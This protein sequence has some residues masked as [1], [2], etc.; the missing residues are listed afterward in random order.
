MGKLAS[1]SPLPST[2]CPLG[3]GDIWYWSLTFRVGFLDS[4][5]R[6]YSYPV[7]GSECVS[8]VHNDSGQ[9]LLLRSHQVACRGDCTTEMA[10]ESPWHSTPG[11]ANGSWIRPTGRGLLAATRP[12]NL[13]RYPRI[14]PRRSNSTTATRCQLVARTARSAGVGGVWRSLGCSVRGKMS[15]TAA[16]LV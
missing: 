7:H 6:N 16:D 12:R 11:S 9:Y 8:V 2:P 10:R 15:C 13:P 1:G 5:V 14:H 4:A 3:F